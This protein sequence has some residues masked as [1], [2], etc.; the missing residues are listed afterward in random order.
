MDTSPDRYFCVQPEPETGYWVSAANHAAAVRACIQDGRLRP[1]DDGYP[2]LVQVEVM[3]A[4]I[5]LGRLLVSHLCQRPDEFCDGFANW[6]EDVVSGTETALAKLAEAF[7]AALAAWQAEGY[8]CVNEMRDS[9]PF[10]EEERQQF[11][12][13]WDTGQVVRCDP[14]AP[15]EV[16]E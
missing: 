5:P 6:D 2:R 12:V 8:G 14:H 11:S 1:D 9:L 10:E 3:G 15:P 16:Q 13:N 4:R 7:E